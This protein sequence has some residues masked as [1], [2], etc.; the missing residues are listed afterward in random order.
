MKNIILFFAAVALANGMPTMNG[1]TAKVAGT[2]Q[3]IV[4]YK[5][6]FKLTTETNTYQLSFK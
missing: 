6:P 1:Q 2:Y 5:D 4:I 3:L